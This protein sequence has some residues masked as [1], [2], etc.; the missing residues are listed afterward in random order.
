LPDLEREQR[1][2]LERVMLLRTFPAFAELAPSH[3]AVLA[4]LALERSFPAG[5][6][7]HPEGLPVR[8]VHYVLSGEVEIRRR[9]HLVKRLGPRSVIG[10]LAALARLRDGYQV[11]A[12]TDATTFSFSHED[13][14]D[15][16]EDNFEIMTG[17]L[18]GVAGAYIEERREA[19][20]MA[21]F[22]DE[23]PDPGPLPQQA[24][25]L[26]G[27]LAVLRRTT[28]FDLAEVEALAELAR[29]S[30][31]RRYPSGATL[32][33]TGDPSGASLLVVAGVIEGRVPGADQRF[34]LG[35]GSI[36]GGLDSLAGRPR[37]FDAVAASELVGLEVGLAALLD[38]L[39]DHTGM[40]MDVLRAMAS[41]VLALRERT[42][43]GQAP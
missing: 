22:E 32:W 28:P 23:E 12:A 6:E 8:E 11:V 9:G 15:V 42:P 26:V 36:A 24:L 19:G 25:G 30:P 40:A 41:G 14:V 5:S 17:V 34:R 21:G 33:Q 13:Q 29:D 39:E 38:V 20:A 43:A 3:L 2:G 27:K 7:I 37:W 31:E 16:F 35:P 10:G 4:E 18:R 1:G